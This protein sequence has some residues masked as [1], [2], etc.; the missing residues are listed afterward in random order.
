M[1]EIVF[2][3][4]ADRHRF[5]AGACRHQQQKGQDVEPVRSIGYKDPATDKTDTPLTEAAQRN[6][7]NG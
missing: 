7:G 2:F 4:F 6:V 1:V 5:G 3:S